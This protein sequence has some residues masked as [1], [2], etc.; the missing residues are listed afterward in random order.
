[1]PL[2]NCPVDNFRH[3]PACGAAYTIDESCKE[4]VR[5]HTD[6]RTSV[7]T[8]TQSVQRVSRSAI[9]CTSTSQTTIGLEFRDFSRCTEIGQF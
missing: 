6:V 1:M 3:E 2:I 5:D 9:P 4:T 7:S 8:R